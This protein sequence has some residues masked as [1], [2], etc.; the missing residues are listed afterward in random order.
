MIKFEN[1]K[2]LFLRKHENTR[3]PRI[4]RTG[5]DASLISPL[6]LIR[7]WTDGKRRSLRMRYLTSMKKN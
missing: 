2:R 1:F 6:T 4:S 7:P 3:T 5:A